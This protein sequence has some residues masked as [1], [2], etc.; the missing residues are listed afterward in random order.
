MLDKS[1]VPTPEQIMSVFP[2]KKDLVKPH[3]IIECYEEIPCNPCETS[4]AFKAITIGNN[5]NAKPVIDIEKCS[6]CSICVTRCP[7]LA[8]MVVQLKGD[9][10]IFKIPYEFLPVPKVGEIWSGVN[11]SGEVICDALIENVKADKKQN[12]TILVTAVVDEKYLYEFVTI[13]RKHE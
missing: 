4:C 5:I 10:A 9:K 7:G 2:D 11:R 13:R 8:I 12:H 3:A 6:G 1:G